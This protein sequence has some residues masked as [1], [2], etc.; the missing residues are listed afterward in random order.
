MMNS[1]T[2]K[3]RL[4]KI[5]EKLDRIPCAKTGLEAYA[6][7]CN[8]VNEIEDELFEW[9]LPRTFLDGTITERLY[10][11]QPECME[12][13]SGWSGIIVCVHVKEFIFFSRYGAVEIQLDTSEDEKLIHFSTRSSA[14]IYSKNDAY[15]DPVWHPKNKDNSFERVEAFRFLDDQPTGSE[16]ANL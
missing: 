13:V 12:S 14:V 4:S 5:F 10:P 15:G 16:F 2:K 8:I 9:R 6:R 7:L 11:P 1:I 3:D